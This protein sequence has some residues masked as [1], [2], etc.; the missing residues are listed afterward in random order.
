MWRSANL[1]A[2]GIIISTSHVFA[3]TGHDHLSRVG[4]VNASGPSSLCTAYMRKDSSRLTRPPHLQVRDGT[5]RGS[6]IVDYAV[7]AIEVL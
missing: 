4:V 5:Y 1:A 2:L 3:V 6:S 7:R